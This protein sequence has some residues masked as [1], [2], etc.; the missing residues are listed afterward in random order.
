MYSLYI[1]TEIIG[2]YME[3]YV[4]FLNVIAMIKVSLLREEERIIL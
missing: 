3:I 1:E 4:L 2:N